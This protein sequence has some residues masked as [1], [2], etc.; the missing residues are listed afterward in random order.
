MP[1]YDG[2]QDAFGQI[3][4]PV[5]QGTDSANDAV[6]AATSLG[7]STGTPI[8]FVMRPYPRTHS[9]TVLAFLAA[10]T[11][12]LHQLGYRSAVYG[13]VSPLITDLVSHYATD[14]M[15][16][17]IAFARW[18]GADNVTDPQIPATDWACHCRVHQSS[19]P[20]VETFDGVSLVINEDYWD[21][22]LASGVFMSKVG[23]IPMETLG[24]RFLID[25]DG[26]DGNQYRAGD[27]AQ[28]PVQTAYDL[29]SRGVVEP[30]DGA[31]PLW[32]QWEGTS[33]T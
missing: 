17:V 26:T 5:S 18:N 14:P 25:W 22:Q 29:R 31:D 28:L 7:F 21:V 23:E 32:A 10:W 19:G 33:G 3:T 9:A 27:Q 2:P 20:H 8:Y 1:L 15:P 13:A 6:A 12:R 11:S 16:D 30:L 24:I 4:S